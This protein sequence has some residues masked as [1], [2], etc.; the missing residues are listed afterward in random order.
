MAASTRP[1]K[2]RFQRS[3]AWLGDSEYPSVCGSYGLGIF[4]ICFCKNEL[5]TFPGFSWTGAASPKDLMMSPIHL[6]I[7][8][9]F[10]DKLQWQGLLLD[11]HVDYTDAHLAQG[12]KGWKSHF[13]VDKC[14]EVRTLCHPRSAVMVFAMDVLPPIVLASIGSKVFWFQLKAFP[15]WCV[16]IRPPALSRIFWPSYH[17][18]K[19]NTLC[20]RINFC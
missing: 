9:N 10:K 2:G 11:K 16:A 18:N 12:G 14:S 15:F 8:T 13:G 17:T 20:W 1:Q 6:G 3:C 5:M 19:P 7:S 4:C